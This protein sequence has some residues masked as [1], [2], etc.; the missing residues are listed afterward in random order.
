MCCLSLHSLSSTAALCCQRK[1]RGLTQVG[2]AWGTTPS[3]HNSIFFV[4]HQLPGFLHCLSCLS[5]QIPGN[6]KLELSSKNILPTLCL[7]CDVRTPGTSDRTSET[8]S[9]SYVP[10]PTVPLTDLKNV[11]DENLQKLPE[12]SFRPFNLLVTDGA[13]TLKFPVHAHDPSLIPAEPQTCS[14]S[15][16][17]LIAHAS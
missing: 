1:C 12:S 11:T 7:E 15:A 10:V 13:W 17:P 9:V 16:C 5:C 4:S 3:S 6:L 14:Q 2:S 8:C